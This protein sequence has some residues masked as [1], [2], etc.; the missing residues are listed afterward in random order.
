MPRHAARF[1]LAL[2]LLLWLP[3]PGGACDICAVYTGFELQRT[4]SGPRFGIGEQFTRFGTLQQNGHEVDNPAGE[5][6]ESSITQLLFGYQFNRRFGLQLNLPIIHRGYRRRTAGGVENGSVAGFGD[7]S[8]V[9]NVLVWDYTSEESVVLMTGFAGLQLPSGDSSLLGEESG[10]PP[11]TPTPIDPRNPPDFFGSQRV[12]VGGARGGR[13]A[14]QGDGTVESGIHGHDLAP[15]SGAVDGLFGAQV[16]ASWRRLYG[17]GLIQYSVNS[18]GSFD[19]RYANE[20]TAAGGPGVFLLLDDDY[21]FG[22]QALVGVDTKGTDTVDG[23]REDATGFTALYFGPFF[24]FTWSTELS[25]DFGIGF[26]LIDNNTGLQIVPDWR[27]RAGAVW[28][29]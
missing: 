22:G 6:L 19:Y 9:A 25:A 8:L 18:T 3:R 21:T 23:E 4:E 24:H 12:E 29:F 28:R 11:P 14:D 10:A 27:L 15:G 17:S 26:P 1:V 13:H 2:V 7:L 5:Y 20:L 16:F